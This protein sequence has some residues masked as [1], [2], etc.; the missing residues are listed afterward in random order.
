MTVLMRVREG[1]GIKIMADKEVYIF[2][3]LRFSVAAGVEKDG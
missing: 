1:G 3:L 2:S